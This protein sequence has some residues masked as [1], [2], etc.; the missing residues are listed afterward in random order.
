NNV[1]VAA[2]N[3][4][5]FDDDW[6]LFDVEC[7][8]DTWNYDLEKLDTAIITHPNAAVLLVHNMGGIINKPQL[9]K[10]YPNTIFVE[11]ACEAFLGS[12]E[13]QYAGTASFVSA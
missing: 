13:N 3:A 7:D 1:Y 6:K 2:I 4:F 5:L 8:G 9:Q 12:Y 11:D 10:K